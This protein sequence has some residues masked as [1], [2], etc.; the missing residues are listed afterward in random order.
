MGKISYK[1]VLILVVIV[2]TI[3]TG[4][5]DKK[6][7]EGISSN[8][9]S[10]ESLNNISEMILPY[11]NITEKEKV[12]PVKALMQ[13]KTKTERIKNI[14]NV[15][16][17]DFSQ[18]KDQ[19]VTLIC[20][21]NVNKSWGNISNYNVNNMYGSQVIQSWSSFV[22]SF[23]DMIHVVRIPNT[24]IRLSINEPTIFEVRQNCSQELI[25]SIQ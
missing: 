4:C 5:V 6:V 21:Q 7:N 11:S 3:I 18:E 13:N 22:V 17:M 1:I 8:N 9:T 19:P 15:Q 23:E 16:I 10:N 2:L 20:L 14:V 12:V 25:E 24:G